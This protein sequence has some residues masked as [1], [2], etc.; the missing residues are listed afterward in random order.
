MKNFLFIF[1]IISFAFAAPQ[2]NKSIKKEIRNKIL[3]CIIS[4]EGISDNLKKNINLIK[5]SKSLNPIIFNKIKMEEND[6]EVVRACKRQ[7]FQEVRNNKIL[8]L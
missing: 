4:T 3:N 7:V 2:V 5:E 6:M 8:N 1:F